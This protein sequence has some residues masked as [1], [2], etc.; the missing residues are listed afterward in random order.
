M[1]WISVNDSLP[2]IPDGQ[3]GVSVI[4][5]VHDPV[6]EHLNPGK[7]SHTDNL[8]WDGEKFETIAYGGKGDWGWH[9]M[10]DIV[11]HWMYEPK[12]FQVTDKGFKFNPEG[13]A[14]YLPDDGSEWSR[15]EG[16]RDE[17]NKI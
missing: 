9:E 4:C 7:G 3:H 2:E 10:V 12:A 13:Y 1:K 8:H 5:S 14:G 11:T 17:A 15:D 16:V 6:Y